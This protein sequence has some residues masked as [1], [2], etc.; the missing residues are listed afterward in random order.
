MFF[1]YKKADNVEG[2]NK[3]LHNFDF[4]IFYGIKHKHPYVKYTFS[5]SFLLK[6]K[7][8]DIHSE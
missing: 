6:K 8:G 7:K 3:N 2:I 1:E 4:F 5:Q